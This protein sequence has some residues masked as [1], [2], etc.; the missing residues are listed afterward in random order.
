[1]TQLEQIHWYCIFSW[2]VSISILF[3]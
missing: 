3:T 1:M 2:H